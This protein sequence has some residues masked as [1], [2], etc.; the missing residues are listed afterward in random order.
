[1]NKNNKNKNNNNLNSTY[2]N[3]IKENENSLSNNK[4]KQPR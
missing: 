3:Y 4:T 1:M 2:S